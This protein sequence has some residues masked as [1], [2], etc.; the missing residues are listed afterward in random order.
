MAQLL[1]DLELLSL[2]MLG[3]NGSSA[4]V[5]CASLARTHEAL[6]AAPPLRRA[7]RAGAAAAL[8]PKSHFPPSFLQ[9]RP[10]AVTRCAD[11]RP[12]RS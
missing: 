1:T 4:K 12:W 9:K 6:C 5:C 2:A 11:R 10:G 8:H 7:P 3:G